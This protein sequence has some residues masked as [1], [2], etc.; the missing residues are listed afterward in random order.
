MKKGRIIYK[1]TKEQFLKDCREEKLIAKVTEG[2][3]KNVG[4]TTDTI[5]SSWNG[6]LSYLYVLLEDPK[7]PNTCGVS[8]EQCIPNIDTRK[9]MDVVLTGKDKHKRNSMIIL[10]L[11]QWSKVQ[12]PSDKIGFVVMKSSKKEKEN[13]KRPH[14]AS[15]ALGYANFVKRY[16]DVIE[17]EEIQVYPVAYLHNYIREE[18]DPLFDERYKIVIDK[19]PIFIRG[20]REKLRDFICDKICYGDNCEIID[21]IDNSPV[22]IPKLIEIGMPNMMKE[23]EG[24]VLIDEQELIYEKAIQMAK[25][26]KEDKKKRVLIVKGGVGTG[27]SILAMK[28][29][30]HFLEDKTIGLEE[31][32]YITP[33]SNQR[34]IYSYLFKKDKEHKELVEKLKSPESYIKVKENE[35]DVLIV[36]ESHRLKEKSG[37]YKNKGENQTKEII[38]AS[39]FS[40]FFIDNLQRIT[41]K[42]KGNTEEIL[43]IAKEQEAEVEVEIDELTSQFRCNGSKSYVSWIEDVLQIRDTANHDGFDLNLNYDVQVV[44]DPNELRDFIIKKNNRKRNNKIRNDSRMVAGLCWNSEKKAWNESEIYDI[45]IPKYNFEASWNLQGENWAIEKDAVKRVGCIYTCQGFDFDYIGVIIGEDL[46]YRDGKVQA[47]ETKKADSDH[48]LLGIKTIRKKNKLEAKRLVDEIIKNT[49]RVLLTRGQ[50]G[51][52]IFCVDDALRDYLKERLK[53]AKNNT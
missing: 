43:K 49:Y 47:D 53:E 11:K 15:Q 39:K 20:E 23:T 10:E 51:C 21:K 25:Q 26:C 37:F 33:V 4:K 9:R 29:L 7:I 22:S 41:L 24:I 27:K 48:A 36:D 19:C 16:N 17:K 31:I 5:V 13:G 12:E 40:I 38:Q 30:A 6:S 52:V 2:Y 1:A 34:K 28:L 18:K 45:Q 14:P 44:D 8:I 35:K 42:D 50:S 3:I 32:Q 46:I